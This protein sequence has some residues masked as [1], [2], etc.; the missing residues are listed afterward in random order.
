M[1]TSDISYPPPQLLDHPW[2]RLLPV[3]HVA[4]LIPMQMQAVAR[5]QQFVG[6]LGHGVGRLVGIGGI[7][8]T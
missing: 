8:G 6:S 3:E 7:L 2:D 4:S 5:V 1:P